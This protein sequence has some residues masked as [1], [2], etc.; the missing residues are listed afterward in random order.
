MKRRK[1]RSRKP[2][3]AAPAPE[4]AR[5]SRREVLRR[6]RNWSIGISVAGASGWFMIKDV[7]ATLREHDLSQIGNGVAAVVQ[8][9]DPNCSMCTA[10]QRETRDAIC[11]IDSPDLQYLVA[12]IHTDEGRKLAAAHGV[13][14]V[15]LLLFDGDGKRHGIITGTKD[16][17]YLIDAYRQHLKRIKKS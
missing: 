10:L 7:R 9:H 5:P 11:E 6:V 2:A 8:I 13:G 12:N 17:T 1:K 4:Q 15:T 14:H 16:S 3:A